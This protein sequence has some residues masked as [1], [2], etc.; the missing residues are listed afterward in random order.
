MIPLTTGAQLR[1]FRR[2]DT[3][4][5][6]N[7]AQGHHPFQLVHISTAHHR[8]NLE[9]ACAHALKRQVKPLVEVDMGKLNSTHELAQFLLI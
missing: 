1:P 2:A 9:L 6:Q 7:I 5:I 3:V 4:G 8:Q